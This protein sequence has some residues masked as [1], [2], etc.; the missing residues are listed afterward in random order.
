MRIS[1][2]VQTCA[3]PISVQTTYTGAAASVV[4]TRITQVLE[5][6]LAGIAGIKTIT[7]ESEDGESRINI[8]FSPTRDVDSAANDVR[9]RVSGAV[10]DLPEEALA[11]EIRKVDADRSEAHTSELPS[12]MRLT[13]SL[14]CLKQT[15]T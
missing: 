13:S 8:E 5:E 14:L 15:Q 1:A 10:G 2:G 12:L 7:S 3:L 6:R 9:D 4:E 11:P